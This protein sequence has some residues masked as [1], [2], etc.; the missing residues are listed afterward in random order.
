MA[1]GKNKR[2]TKCVA[3]SGVDS[4]GL[5]RDRLSSQSERRGGAQRS[6]RAYTK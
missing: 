6:P 4:E 5:Q 2:L 3:A 1:I